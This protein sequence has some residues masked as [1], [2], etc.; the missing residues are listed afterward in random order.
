MECEHC[1]AAEAQTG[2]QGVYALENAC[3]VGRLIANTPQLQRRRTMLEWYEKTKGAEFVEA[4]KVEIL[5]RF[6]KVKK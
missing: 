4:V 1:K 2:F 5:K 6:E 3:C